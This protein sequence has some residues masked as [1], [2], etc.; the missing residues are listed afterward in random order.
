MLSIPIET[1]VVEHFETFIANS[2]FDDDVG[3]ASLYPRC[4]LVISVFLS[5]LVPMINKTKISM[6]WITLLLHVVE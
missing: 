6:L 3:I 1:N 2:I 4:I 5:M